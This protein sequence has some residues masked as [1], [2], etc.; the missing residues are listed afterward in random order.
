MTPTT[1]LCPECHTFAPC[2]EILHT[3]EDDTWTIKYTHECKNDDCLM[4]EFTLV[5]VRQ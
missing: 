2:T 1:I 4:S 3:V 5:E